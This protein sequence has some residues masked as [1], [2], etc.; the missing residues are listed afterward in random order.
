MGVLCIVCHLQT[1]RV[2]LLSQS[3]FLLF[4]FL[5]WLLW[6]ELPKLY[7]RIVVRVGTLV[8][9]FRGNTC[10]FST[11]RIM[12][13]VGLL[14]MAF[15]MLRYIPFKGFPSGLDS[16]ESA[17]SAGDASLIPGSGRSSLEWNGNPLQYSCLENPMD[18][19]AWQATVH[20]LTKSQTWLND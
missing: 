19:G 10:N 16:K 3:G 11:L 8:P 13:S 17:C 7:W 9:E 6:L 18:R 2:L 1:V 20:G 5:L 15:T 12:F 4:L 14:Y